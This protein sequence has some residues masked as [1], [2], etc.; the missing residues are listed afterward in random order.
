MNLKLKIIIISV[1]VI[2]LLYVLR[3]VKHSH[4]ST[5]YS[6]VWIITD[7]LV[8]IATIFVDELFGLAKLLG[9]ET[10]S[11]LMFFVGFIFLLV[12][13]FNLSYQLSIQNKKIIALTQKLGLNET[14]IKKQ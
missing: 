8:I 12:M 2:L 10:V 14:E 6:L 4:F 5:K 9:I 11:N 1:M 13:C 3:K 7:V